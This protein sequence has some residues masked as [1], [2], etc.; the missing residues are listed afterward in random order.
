MRVRVL[1]PRVL[2]ELELQEQVLL[3][4]V[5][6]VQEQVRRVLLELQ[7]QAMRVLQERVLQ[8]MLELQSVTTRNRS[9]IQVVVADIQIL[10]M[11]DI[12]V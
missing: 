4:L 3:G 12:D 7:E 6:Q 5:L 11:D 2:L 10:A 1:V 9:R 8:V